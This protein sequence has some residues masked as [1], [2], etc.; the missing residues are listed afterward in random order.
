MGWMTVMA[1]TTKLQ[2]WSYCFIFQKAEKEIRGS[3]LLDLISTNGE[4]L[5][6]NQRSTNWDLL[7]RYSQFLN[8]V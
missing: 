7:N 1:K 6:E 5:A 4:E 2:K 8:E 3:S